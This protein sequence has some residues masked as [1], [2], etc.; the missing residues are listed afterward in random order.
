MWY[1]TYNSHKLCV[2]VKY[3]GEFGVLGQYPNGVFD[4]HIV[5]N[6][7]FVNINTIFTHSENMFEMTQILQVAVELTGR[8][9]W[10]RIRYM[11][12]GRGQQCVL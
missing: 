9:F 1:I 10:S 4:I 12:A 11:I 2:Q 8:K 7:R 5:S 3:S 6:S